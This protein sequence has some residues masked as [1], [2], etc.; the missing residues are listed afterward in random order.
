M[1]S[2]AVSL[3]EIASGEQCPHEALMAFGY[4]INPLR[5]VQS[6][7]FEGELRQIAT[8]SGN[9]DA[10]PNTV[11]AFM[12]VRG[13]RDAVF[14]G[15]ATHNLIPWLS[16]IGPIEFTDV[17]SYLEAAYFGIWGVANSLGRYCSNRTVEDPSW[18]LGKALREQVRRFYPSTI[19]S[20]ITE[21]SYRVEVPQGRTGY[22][23]IEEYF[24]NLSI[25]ARVLMNPN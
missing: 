23:L 1:V 20:S 11:V 6:S 9:A 22:S 15:L 18:S 25:V 10:D 4:M 7:L 24:P 16:A 5:R 21:P 3:E 2:E 8:L 13:G 19:T 12:M 17:T 14:A